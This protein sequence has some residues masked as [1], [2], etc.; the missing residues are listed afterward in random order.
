MGSL[1]YGKV[2]SVG[3]AMIVEMLVGFFCTKF[4]LVKADRI[5]TVNRVCFLTYYLPLAIRFL[6]SKKL[7]ELDFTPFVVNAIGNIMTQIV[8]LVML[9]VKT[10]DRFETY[11]STFFPSCYVNYVIIGFP[12]YNSIWGAESNVIVS[13]VT[14]SNDLISTPIFL[15]E[16]GIYN[17]IKRN[18]IHR[19]KGE[20]EERI[21]L[22]FFWNIL[23]VLLSSPI[24]IGDII[25]FIISGIGKG[26]PDYIADLL[27]IYGNAVNAVSL[28][29]VG[30][31]LAAHAI[32]ACP[33]WQFILCLLFRFVLFPIMVGLSA[34]MLGVSKTMGRVC[35]VLST[36]PTASS[37]Y[38]MAEGANI[39]SGSSTTMIFWTMLLFVPVVI[40]W[41]AALDGLGIFVE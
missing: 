26:I 2:I 7:S 39:D 40:A 33:I 20:E 14:M 9:F 32:I 17:I 13:L 19:E 11:V 16:T 3:G 37:C 36:L 1:D 23:K 4:K 34:A 31:F 6:A 10:D 15:I 25:G 38:M 18:R 5:P 28:F 24:I 12:I 35:V 29:N 27:D 8:L 21:N 30:G 41:F 22:M